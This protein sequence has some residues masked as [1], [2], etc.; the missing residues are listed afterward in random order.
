M[1]FAIRKFSDKATEG[2]FK[3]LQMAD[4][5]PQNDLMQPK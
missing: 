3:G 5:R 1:L 4:K 2:I